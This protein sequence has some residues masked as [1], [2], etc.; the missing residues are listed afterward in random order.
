ML[1]NSGNKHQTDPLV[2]TQ[3]VRHSSTYIILYIYPTAE[4]RV[5][6]RPRKRPKEKLDSLSR[7]VSANTPLTFTQRAATFI[8]TRIAEKSNVFSLYIEYT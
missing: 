7:L 2:N 5:V 4:Q 6:A 3:T 8:P 1:R